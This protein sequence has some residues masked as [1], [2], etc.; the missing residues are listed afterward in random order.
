MDRGQAPRNFERYDRQNG[1]VFQQRN[2]GNSRIMKEEM[3]L[4]EGQIK[5]MAE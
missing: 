5:T 2:Q 4:K 3:M 1:N